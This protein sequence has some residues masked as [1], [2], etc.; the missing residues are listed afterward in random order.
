MKT[1]LKEKEDKSFL[2]AI[3]GDMS[4]KIPYRLIA[5]FLLNSLS[6]SLP[7]K[8]KEGIVNSIFLSDMNS[9]VIRNIYNVMNGSVPTC[10]FNIHQTVYC[11]GKAYKYSP[12]PTEEG[13][14]N[15]A[16]VEIGKAKIL[17]YNPFSSEPYEIEYEKQNSSGKYFTVTSRYDDSHIRP[18]TEAL[19]VEDLDEA[20]QNVTEDVE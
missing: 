19:G 13:K 9:Q 17:S 10:P 12:D 5:E 2:G 14:F 6:G 11:S 7:N 18:I 4:I 20:K 1:P 15:E 3:Q 8:V 16:Y